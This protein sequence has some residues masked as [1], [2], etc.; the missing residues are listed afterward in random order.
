MKL[1]TERLRKKCIKEKTFY[2]FPTNE[3]VLNPPKSK[4]NGIVYKYIDEDKNTFFLILYFKEKEKRV[5]Y[6]LAKYMKLFV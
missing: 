5:F 4:S 1:I 3:I 6:K 2:D